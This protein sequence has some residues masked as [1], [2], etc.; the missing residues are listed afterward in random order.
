MAFAC[1]TQTDQSYLFSTYTSLYVCNVQ[2]WLRR[3]HRTATRLDS[4]TRL[5][6]PASRFEALFGME[7]SATRFAGQA[8]WYF[9]KLPCLADEKITDSGKR[10]VGIAL[11]PIKFFSHGE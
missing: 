11:V 4:G 5:V 3:L 6:K 1:I 2:T 8:S 7:L 9:G 10:S